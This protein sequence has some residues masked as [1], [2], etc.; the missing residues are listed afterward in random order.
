LGLLRTQSK[1][2]GQGKAET[3]GVDIV[4]GC[5]G[6]N[7]D[8]KSNAGLPVIGEKK[9][10]TRPCRCNGKDLTVVVWLT[11]YWRLHLC[12]GHARSQSLNNFR[13]KHC[14]RGL[15]A[16]PGI[17]MRSHALGGAGWLGNGN[18]AADDMVNGVANDLANGL[19]NGIANGLGNN[20][21]GLGNGLAFGIVFGKSKAKGRL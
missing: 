20:G 3:R 2:F 10:D 17:G 1:R 16:R 8:S 12:G 14:Q 18:G 7:R 9:A 4:G 6:M 5:A 11:I 15:G 19:G 13:Q 21:N